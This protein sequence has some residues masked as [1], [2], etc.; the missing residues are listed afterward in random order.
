M[1]SRFLMVVG[2]AR[3]IVPAQPSASFKIKECARQAALTAVK[4][5]IEQVPRKFH[6][7]RDELCEYQSSMCMRNPYSTSRVSVRR[8]SCCEA[9]LNLGLQLFNVLAREVSKHDDFN[10][11]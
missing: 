3:S 7:R 5:R 2:K 9:I 11:R 1:N 4:S 10:L 6:R 8:D